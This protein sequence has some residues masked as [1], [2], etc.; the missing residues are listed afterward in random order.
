MLF[1]AWAAVGCVT[2]FGLLYGFTPIGPLFL[3]LGWLAFAY[4]PTVSGT[5]RPEAF[6]GL[7]GFG[8]FWL[9]IATSV[10]GELP[11]AVIGT[12]SV[13][14]AALAYAVDGRAR[15]ASGGSSSQ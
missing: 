11:F 13:A 1:M 2:S 8:F 6:G 12:S 9:F 10:Q 4:M 14:L 7:A 3:A 15:C 5:R